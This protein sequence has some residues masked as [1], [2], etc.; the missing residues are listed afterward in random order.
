VRFSTRGFQKHQ[1]QLFGGCP[2]Q[3]PFAKKVEQKTFS[4]SF[5]PFDFLFITF[6]AVSLHAE[7]KNT[8]QMALKTPRKA[9]WYL[10]R[11]FFLLS[12]PCFLFL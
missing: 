4:P 7:L 8:I 3:K 6:L 12:A 11:F 2:C 10:P 9:P 1:K 5:F